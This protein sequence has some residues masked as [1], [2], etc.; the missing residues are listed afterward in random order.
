VVLYEIYIK[1]YEYLICPWTVYHD[2]NKLHSM[3]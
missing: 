1:K 3:I 2:A